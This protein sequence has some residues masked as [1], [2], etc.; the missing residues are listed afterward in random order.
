MVSNFV[1]HELESCLAAHPSLLD[2]PAKALTESYV[3]VD[4]SLAAA[5][6]RRTRCCRYFPGHTISPVLPTPRY[7][8]YTER[9]GVLKS[10][11]LLPH[12]VNSPSTTPSK[13]MVIKIRGSGACWLP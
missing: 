11:F 12:L 9:W 3:K 13:D 10:T 5:K 1:M 2:D 4:Q 7:L 8:K 6:V